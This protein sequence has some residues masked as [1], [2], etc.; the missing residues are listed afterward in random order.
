MAVYARSSSNTRRPFSAISVVE[1][2]GFHRLTKED[3]VHFEEF[4]RASR[5]LPVSDEVV[6]AA[7]RLRQT[8][9]MSL[10]DALIAG[11]ALVYNLTLVTGNT[12]D[13]SWVDRLRLHNP[14][15]S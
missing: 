8:R 14:L 5:V 11:T 1:V 6:E 15:G 13:F 10:G 4:F 2:L 12:D 9:R 3:R 7:V